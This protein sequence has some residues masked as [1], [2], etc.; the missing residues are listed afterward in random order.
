MIYIAATTNKSLIQDCN[1]ITE[2]YDTPEYSK[3]LYHVILN[4]LLGIFMKFGYIYTKY[5]EGIYPVQGGML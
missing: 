1:S 4:F 3:H 2:L 5:Q